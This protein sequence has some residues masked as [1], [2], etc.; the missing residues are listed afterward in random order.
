[1]NDYYVVAFTRDNP[2]AQDDRFHNEGVKLIKESAPRIPRDISKE[3]ASKLEYAVVFSLPVLPPDIR[4]SLQEG[5]NQ[6]PG[7]KHLLQ[8]ELIEAMIYPPQEYEQYGKVYFLNE[9]ALRMYRLGGIT[10]DILRKISEE[11]LPKQ[12]SRSLRGPYIPS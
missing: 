12:C 3:Q 7:A 6:S 8:E 9:V 2:L 1:M 10:F 11:E 5:Y 4:Q